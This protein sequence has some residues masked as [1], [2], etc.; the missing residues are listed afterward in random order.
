MASRP[1]VIFITGAGS[2]IGQLAARQALAAGDAV[3][4]LDIDP[5]GLAALGSVPRLL[6][7]TV[8]VTDAE[9]VRRA[10]QETEERLGPIDRVV[11]AA[12]IMPLGLLAQ[13][14][15]AQIHKVMAINY[16]G[17]VNV[18]HAALPGMVA[19]GR[20]EFVSFSS[21]AGHIPLL[22]MGAYDASKAAVCAFTE[23]LAH[24]HRRSG[25]TFCCV[26]P[27]PVAT[28]LLQQAQNTVWPKMFDIAPAI[29][30]EQVLEATER[31]LARGRFWVFPGPLVGWLVLLRRLWP[32]LLWWR[33]HQVEGR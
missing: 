32:G 24:E 31:A 23:V 9:A 16:G 30:A 11:N 5:A 10:V 3:A 19:R 28:P 22:Y 8:D 29:T 2:G 20:G 26:C 7:I 1:K 6:C 12:A 14:P 27:P 18:S 4:A 21:S 25:V 17:L 33:V 15:N 13:Q